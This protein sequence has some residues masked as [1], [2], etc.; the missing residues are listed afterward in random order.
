VQWL[1]AGKGIVHCEMFPLVNRDADNPVEL[2]QLWL[3]LPR[4]NKMV[5][6]HFSM[7]WKPRIPIV[8]RRDDRGRPSRITVVAGAF[9]DV[10]PPPPPPKSW[11]SVPGS[12]VA[13]WSIEL[14]ADATLSLP[15]ASAGT[16][17]TVYVFRGAPVRVEGTEVPKGVGVAVK[18]DEPLLLEGGAGGSEVLVLQGRP[19][20]EPVAQYGPFVMN[21]QHEILEA[22]ADYRRTEF[23]GWP[24]DRDDP[25]HAR[26]QL[27][28]ARHA[29]GRVEQA[30]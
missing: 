10:Q 17:R 29:D 14:S 23:G 21:S 2:F 22:F 30:P 18:A 6:P 3:N 4:A 15:P 16:N 27:R 11:A 1:T 20:K 9:E 28:F 26:E 19:I 7:L 24:F 8:E 12:D 13:I 5:E 25:V